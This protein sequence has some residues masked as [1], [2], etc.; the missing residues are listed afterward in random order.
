MAKHKEEHCKMA[1][2]AKMASH[3]LKKH[4]EKEEMHHEVKKH[5]KRK[6]K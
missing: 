6:A 4:H 3:G 5:S 1:Q 2:K